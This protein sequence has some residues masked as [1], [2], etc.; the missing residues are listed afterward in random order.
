MTNTNLGRLSGNIVT[1]AILTV[2]FL[3]TGTAA[4]K[5]IDI[6][7]KYAF[8]PAA[9]W[10]NFNPANGGVMVYDSHLEG[11]AWSANAGWVRLGT[12]TGGGTHT[13]ANDSATSYGVNNDGAGNLSGYGWS[14]VA[15]WINFNPSS[16]GVSIDP[17]T[18]Q[19]SGYAWSANLGWI[20][21]AGTAQ[22]TTAYQVKTDTNRY[23]MQ[24]TAGTGSTI[25]LK[26]DGTLLTAG[27]SDEDRTI[28]SGWS[29]II[30]TAAGWDTVFGLRA[31]G[32]VVAAG[33]NSDGQTDVSG[34]TNIIQ[35]AAGRYHTAGLKADGTVVTAGADWDG[36]ADVGAWTDIIQVAAG[37]YNTMGL[38]ADGSV[39][40]TAGW[41]D[42]SDVTAWTDII[43]VVMGDLFAAGLKSDGTVVVTGMTED[44]QAIV[45]AWQDMVQI[46]AGSAHLTGLKADGTVVA[47]GDD[48]AG[49]LAVSAWT[50]IIQVAAG[51]S[52]TAG[53]KAD[54]TVMAA[55]DNTNGQTQVADWMLKTTPNTNIQ[56]TVTFLDHDGSTL[57]TETVEHGTAATPPPS[58]A[59]VG[60]TF[61]G[62][63]KDISNIT[64]DLEVFATYTEIN[65]APRAFD[66]GSPFTVYTFTGLVDAIEDLDNVFPA[67]IQVGDAMSG[68]FIYDT[69]TSD[70]GN[71]GNYEL[72]PQTSGIHISVNDHVFGKVHHTMWLSIKNDT[73]I[74]M[75]DSFQDGDQVNI[76]ASI[77]EDHEFFWTLTGPVTVVENT[78]LSD[79]LLN[80]AWTGIQFELYRIGG[81]FMQFTISD[82]EKSSNNPVVVERDSWVQGSLVAVDTENDPL[83]YAIVSG[84]E[85]GTLILDDPG[86]GTFTY[87]PDPGF[88]GDDSFTFKVND[89]LSDSNTA[90][91]SITVQPPQEHTVIFK[92]H[93]GTVLKEELVEYGNPATAP[94]D[95]EREGYTFTGWDVSFDTITA[96]LTVTAQ[97]TIKTYDLSYKAGANGTLSGDVSQ[98]VDHGTNG[99]AV[100]AVP[101]EGHH[102][103]QWSDGST[104][105]PRTDENVIEDIHVTAYFFADDD[106]AVTFD[107]DENQSLNELGWIS[108]HSLSGACQQ[109]GVIDYSSVDPSRGGI[110]GII[111]N[112]QANG[113]IF[114]Y[115]DFDASTLSN[116]LLSY[117]FFAASPIS[118]SYF[119]MYIQLRNQENELI[120]TLDSWSLD[121]YSPWGHSEHNIF[122]ITPIDNLRLYV[123]MSFGNGGWKAD[124]PGGYP[125]Y[126]IIDVPGLPGTQRGY[127]F[128]DNVS[129]GEPEPV[130]GDLITGRITTIDGD[131][132]S[133]VCLDA[134]LTQCSPDTRISETQTDE[135]GDYF[136]YIP[137]GS[138]A[139][140]FANGSCPQDQDYVRVYYDGGSGSSDCQN[141]VP[142]SGG[143]AVN[144]ILSIAINTY[145]L[146]YTAG[147]NGALSGSP[148]Q[149]VNHGSDG[150]AVEA[151]P[152][153]GHHF[154]Q[155]SDG[156]TANPRTD[157]NVTQDI[158]VTAQFTKN[159]YTV[160]FLDH[161]GTILKTETVEHGSSATPPPEPARDGYTF[162]GWDVPVDVITGDLTVTARYSVLLLPDLAV[163]A[164]DFRITA[165]QG[166]E[167]WNPNPGETVNLE[168]TVHNTGT[169]ATSDN[170]WVQV[171]LDGGPADIVAYDLSLYTLAG[172]GLITDPIPAGG[173]A[174]IVIPWTIDGPDRIATLTAVT[175]FETNRARSQANAQGEAEALP[176][177]EVAFNNN[178]V[179]RSL[180]I[181]SPAGDYGITVTAAA[182]ENMV[183][184]IGY[185]L[186]GTARYTWG[187]S[188]PVLGAQVT[189][190]VNQTTYTGRT[191][192][193]GGT[194][195]VDL[196]G[197]PQ[198]MHNA[199]VL[200]D[201]GHL[202][203]SAT[204]VLDVG[205]GPQT[206]DLSIQQMGFAGGTFRIQGETGF[207]VTNDSVVL[208]A[209]VYNNGN[210]DSGM[211]DVSFLDPQ[212][213][214]ISTVS[215]ISLPAFGH[216]WI[217]AEAGWTALEGAQLLKAVA[218][219]A[220]TEIET[221]EINNERTCTLF[222]TDDLPDLTVSGIGFDPGAPRQGDDITIT[223]T[224]QNQ[225]SA[226][227]P[228]GTTFDTAF[229]LGGTVSTTL[230]SDLLPGQTIT[231]AT[232]W[233]ATAGTHSVR[234]EVDS[235]NSVQETHE[236][237]NARTNVLTVRQALPDLRPYYRTWQDISGLSF[238]PARPVAHQA[239]TV[240][241][242]IYNSGTVV[243][244]AGTFF[245]V[246]FHADG[247]AFATTQITLDQD[248]APGASIQAT[249]LWDG[250]DPGTV[251][252]SV[253]VDT[254]DAVA[255][256]NETNNTT[257]KNL[258]IY[259]SD[260]DI[261][262]SG[263][264]FAPLQPLPGSTVTLI[265]TLR[266]SG[267][268]AGGNGMTVAFFQN[269]LD[270]S[271][272]IG[273]VELD[274][275]VAPLGGT[276]TVSFDWT[277]PATSG[278]HTMYAVL[279]GSA[280]QRIMTVTQHPAPNLQVFSEDIS[281]EPALPEI[282]DSVKVQA[283]IRNTE[284]STATDFLIQFYVDV[285]AGGWIDLGAPVSVASL[286]PG[287]STLVT[288]GAEITA[289]RP[290]YGLK[291][292]IIPNAA[293]GDADPDDN[294]AT[295]SFVLAGTP[296][297]DAGPDMDVFVG[298]TVTLDGTG[299]RNA[300]TYDWTLTARPE[301][302]AAE[303]SGTDTSR[304]QFTP[305]LSGIY[306]ARL[307]VSDGNISSLAS[308]VTIT[309]THHTITVTSTDGGSTDKDGENT[310]DHH[311]AIT[312]TASP[313]E[314]YTF[315]GW[316]GDASGTANP[317]TVED[318]T[319]DL[320]MSANFEIITYTV[321]FLDH[322]GTVLKTE[323]VEHGDGATPPQ[324]PA[325]D[326]YTFA[327]WDK[328]FSDVTEDLEVFATYTEINHA[329]RAF[330]SGSPFTVYTFT[331]LV[332]TIDDMANAFPADIQVGDA[333]S[334]RFVYD[335]STSDNGNPGNYELD[336]QTNGIHVSVNGHV[337][338][339]V[340]H[341]IWLSIK[342]DTSI[343]M[344]DSFQDGDQVNI[345]ASIEE[346]H[347]FFWTL[348]GPVTVVEN[349][350][351]SDN[352]LDLAWIGIQFELYRIGGNFMQFTISDV[353][354]SSNNPVV[355]ERDSWVQG[356]LVAVDTEND[357]L[358]YTIVSEPENGTLILDDPGAGTF[359]Y[360]PDRGFTGDDSFTFR[361]N[362]G[363]SD[364]NTATIFITVEQPE[365]YPVVF[366]DHDGTVLKEEL[367]EH[368][369]SATAP[370]DPTREGYTFDGWDVAFDNITAE[371][372]VT[373]QYTIKTYDLSYKAGANGTLTGSTSQ[374]VD[375][376]T[377][378][379]AVEAIPDE[380][381][382][383][384]QWSD[385]STANPRTDENVI[386][387]I[388]VT[389]EFALNPGIITHSDQGTSFLGQWT[390]VTAPDAFQDE[391][392]VTQENGAAFTFD[393]GHTGC[394]TVSLW[395]SQ[396]PER[397]DAVPVEIYDDIT[398]L[399]TVYVNQQAGGGQW[400]ELG[401]Y[402][403]EHG[404]V[405][406]VVSDSSTHT[407][408]VDAVQTT[409]TDNCH[410][411]S[412]VLVPGWNLLTPVH[413]TAGLMTASLWAADI[414]SQGAWI[415]RVQKWDGTGWQSYSPG[416]PFGDFAI[417]PGQGYFV[418]NQ[419]Q[420][421]TTWESI[422]MP[423]PCPMTYEFS[424][425]WNLMGFPL[426][427]HATAS[428]LAEA[429]NV[430]QDHVTRI[431][432]WDGSGWQSYTPG[433]PF[434][435]FDIIP[436]QGY[437]LYSS[438]AQTSY[439]QACDGDGPVCGA[440]V[441]PDVWKEF[442][443]YNLAAIGKSTHD[444]PFIP[445]WRLIGGYWQWGRKGP[446]SSQ[447]YDTNTP[448]FAHG[449]T[450]PG[451]SEANSESISGWDS[452]DAPNGAWSD[453]SKTA[454]DP[455]PAGYRVP[456][457]AQWEGVDDN[458]TQST[459]GTWDSDATNYSSGR[460]FGDDL[461]LPAA[462][463]RY[464]YS[465][466][467]NYRGSNG[468][469]WS[470]SEG[471]SSS[472]A[473]YLY[474]GSSSAYPR[475][476]GRQYGRSV[477]CVA[478]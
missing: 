62:W 67:D 101:D 260:A 167:I 392:M 172:S 150:S 387:N 315:T 93:D 366:K 103:V 21:L 433:A 194:W 117:D 271:D 188:E 287:S 212:G 283:Q 83:T 180:L 30:Q 302:S 364:S 201:D 384:V 240:T 25:G 441:A 337:F 208:K 422:G 205:S 16:G 448:N 286:A 357:P 467:L 195:Q 303:L 397:H 386:G 309:A 3:W 385:G 9:G 458:N 112:C 461:M 460:F 462:G 469:Y 401:T 32:T 144:F 8:S 388:D 262:V 141:A 290:A 258:T 218:D 471:P 278:N 304:P 473:R 31:D 17:S 185:T 349:T 453:S 369:N 143:D 362:D 305:D 426:G 330:D 454:N 239:V 20:K 107:F 214:P 119:N 301:G 2:L 116:G 95:P 249:A 13:Y 131:G 443:C 400:Q 123:G 351:L 476:Y 444:D 105:N 37:W 221:N 71:P 250:A 134:F 76:N 168:I 72:D 147:D 394:H 389:A 252:F 55:G 211:F 183:S 58:P 139:Y 435:S 293:Q 242:D 49:Q 465:G 48:Y 411:V 81:N 57:K 248:L 1:V 128:L 436:G 455:C 203:G 368:G 270:P 96:E 42:M 439:T 332:D 292:D 375:H 102:F 294:A 264:T 417:E 113:S 232:A 478:E 200:V 74:W 227:V 50:D 130:T 36:Q 125:E 98:T 23:D 235:G 73:S 59:R 288:A 427:I 334:G 149:T 158:T 56:Y 306:T 347:E 44:D 374:T 413:Q 420:N 110:A 265:A 446:D 419:A 257:S 268:T 236:D 186:Q 383:F 213:Q 318:I 281:I 437:F 338:G 319:S 146:T 152:D 251:L 432:K 339:K 267:G 463:Y 66:S 163:T 164:G 363:L 356:A 228:A 85:N 104:D 124:G 29:N 300:V 187:T 91:V 429:I 181:G 335:A 307:I 64:E 321:T 395:W 245:D 272:R 475:S 445:S 464:Y 477:R 174:A 407:T 393:T 216:A 285:P 151:V 273:L 346:D 466:A 241:C 424:A 230:V 35:I 34:W 135:N 472:Y 39:V 28:V 118:G 381:H 162:T 197:L 45:S 40:V 138:Q 68:R 100:E 84:P 322:D 399:D 442:D 323:T 52:H 24:I 355:A 416:A 470:S 154:V 373:A 358:T 90:A 277:A 414:D 310:V 253:V 450:G 345:D 295:S 266:N 78:E 15:G 329:P 367:V 457:K 326:G 263:L 340:H 390:P 175:E 142:V 155:W 408:S 99:S 108:S 259:P 261:D 324:D 220:N 421:Q 196:N 33:M 406:V 336:P 156:S 451:S 296:V 350:E 449:P 43:Q 343:W 348:T 169:S 182:P 447:W 63:D 256:E 41:N 171:F 280:R 244:P 192:S 440:Y 179:G 331:G 398:L 425:G 370:D 456:T 360:T 82:V 412:Q 153:E 459:V 404:A 217:T 165:T 428:E 46:A 434:G 314:G 298:Q 60:Y 86:A 289:L 219:S 173:S 97:Y 7:D 11:Y 79:N 222:G 377:N 69:S 38:K 178:Q 279:N 452:S 184:S 166:H 189:L 431:Q 320:T 132:I 136:L 22:D 80:L 133:G 170:L 342:N 354:K 410:T 206:V 316:S 325:R 247:T 88:T 199:T 274:T 312:I 92:D 127:V 313:D 5:G 376:N 77:E 160:T 145:D 27:A 291:V 177:E 282:E 12:H 468:Y 89:G 126:G 403:F 87:T 297:A 423:V 254:G 317:L 438:Q 226:P 359:T 111:N 353:E 378:G 207:A 361:V 53:L 109:A 275:D 10:V 328:D 409:A 47:A 75:E 215:Q 276:R 243:L 161:D 311:G 114:M 148:S 415:T 70:N 94:D 19:F 191:L 14:P 308:T 430:P 223:A 204:L 372:T 224:I 352:L 157:E 121:G 299:S 344:E 238:S 176:V 327:G 246:G 396:D 269:T 202:S 198:G 18:G 237:N 6:D 122:D 61:T 380:G 51:E 379:S 106:G 65:H 233:T 209:L 190:H 229:S 234:A 405:I 231:A 193:P 418:F 255:E 341:N 129:I 474:F 210:A 140:I 284:G 225:G 115:Y 371:L 365:Q 391:S 120:A 137:A 26:T 333:M 159:Q 4:A 54:G 402:Y 382:H